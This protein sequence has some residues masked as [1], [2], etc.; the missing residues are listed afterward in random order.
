ME[1]NSMRDRN[2]SVS[3]LTIQT[4]LI[5]YEDNTVK[6]NESVI[7]DNKTN[8]HIQT[9]YSEPTT[10]STT[11]TCQSPI[12]LHLI[13]NNKIPSDSENMCIDRSDAVQQSIVEMT[14][15]LEEMEKKMLQMQ[16]DILHHKES[17]NI[18]IRNL[19][20]ELGNVRYLIKSPSEYTEQK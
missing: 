3:E 18:N 12:H 19:K 4:D 2:R 14:N 16:L 1:S 20:R 13:V 6:Q 11:T 9:V 15:K 8:P 7:V 17:L 5:E 10:P